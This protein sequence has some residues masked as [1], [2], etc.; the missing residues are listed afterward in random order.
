MAPVASSI[1]KQ[2]TLSGSNRITLTT[3]VLIIG[4][5]VSA[6]GW[7]NS[8]L[9]KSADK[10]TSGIV[11]SVGEINSKVILHDERLI[12]AEDTEKHILESFSNVNK[13]MED[14]KST[15]VDIR[16]SVQKIDRGQAVLEERVKGL[17]RSP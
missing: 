5:I 4:F 1:S 2:D 8:S 3:A 16:S 17:S 15:L 7:F 10:A 13:Q 6:I 12:H 11:K 9:E 14:V